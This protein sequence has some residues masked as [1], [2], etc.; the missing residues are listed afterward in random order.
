MRF[1]SSQTFQPGKGDTRNLSA[2]FFNLKLEPDYSNFGWR[3]W[4]ASFYRPALLALLTLFAWYLA[5]LA[6]LKKS[7]GLAGEVITGA[8]LLLSL[9]FWPG[10]AEPF[11]TGWTLILWG[12]CLAL[13]AAWKFSW[14]FNGS[15]TPF[16]Y[17][18]CFLPLMPLTQ[19]VAG[20]LDFGSLNPGSVSLI[21]YWSAFIFSGLAFYFFRSRFQIVF[22]SLFLAA[23]VLVFGFAHWQVFA[24]NLYRGADFRNYYLQFLEVEQNHGPLYSLQQMAAHPGEAVRMPPAFTLLFWPFT[25]IFGPDVNSALLAWRGVNELLLIPVLMLF[26]HTFKDFFRGNYFWPTLLLLTLNFG[27]LAE[28]IAYGQQNIILLLGLALT[29]YFVKANWDFMAGLALSFPIWIKLFPVLSG[30]F[31]LIERR[32]KSLGGLVLGALVINFLTVVVVGWENTWFYFSRAMWSVN[33]PEPGIS[34]QSWWGF[35]GR[36][37]MAEIGP[38][39]TL[40]FPSF[41][42]PVGYLGALF[43]LAL[44]LVSLWQ[45]RGGSLLEL[46]LKLG[47]L[48]FLALWISPFSWFHYIAAGL[49]SFIPLLVALDRKEAPRAWVIL[50]SLAYVILAFG[51]RETFFFSEAVGLARLGSSY[52]FLAILTLWSLSLALIYR[53]EPELTKEKSLDGF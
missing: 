24:Q 34:N 49:G 11:Y 40:S 41:L 47:A 37:G 14:E 2:L 27:Q 38:D 26:Y 30:T 45:N 13:W 6:C 25:R 33:D 31:F 23:S 32:W 51:G 52:R 12:G 44:T 9:F 50:F 10:A 16:I 7:W 5:D 17:I 20:R 28:T 1:D 29:A 22:L 42:V 15:S 19:F 4:L 21:A 39:F 48:T 43:G 8:L 46:Q 3:G 53:I 35:I 36:W 18:A